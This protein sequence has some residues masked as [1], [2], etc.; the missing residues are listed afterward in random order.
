MYV[1]I[2]NY[3]FIDISFWAIYNDLSRGHPKWWFSKG[4]PPKMA[5]NWVKDLIIINC[6]DLLGSF[7]PLFFL[8]SGFL[9]RCGSEL[10]GSIWNIH[11]P[12]Y[13]ANDQDKRYQGITFSHLKI[14]APWK[15]RFLLETTIFRCYV[16]FRECNS[17]FFPK[18][19]MV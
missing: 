6:P 18:N 10:F 12:N 14:G 17:Q 15:R 8:L 16:S 11:A 4:I 5:L 7:C 1:L 13:P 2:Y 3:S 9:D 19:Q